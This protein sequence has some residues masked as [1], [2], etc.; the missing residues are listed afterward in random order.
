MPPDEPAARQAGRRWRLGLAA[1][2]AGTVVGIVTSLYSAEL[3]Q[4]LEG[5]VRG[6]A[7]GALPFLVTAAVASV[8]GVLSYELA[9]RRR[10]PG[11]ITAG[12]IT[13]GT[14][15][16]DRIVD[17]D[18]PIAGRSLHY[19]ETRRHTGDLVVLLHGLG[20]DANDFRAYLAES[21]HHC[22]ALTLY[23]FNVA[24]RDHPHY[25]PIS[26]ESHA[27]LVGYALQ[28]LRQTYP[29]K[30]ITLVGFSIG[31][32][33]IMLLSELDRE[34]LAQ[35]RIRA[36]VLLDPNVNTATTTISS[37][38]AEVGSDSSLKDLVSVLR[39]AK[40]RAEFRYLCEYLTKIT[41]KDFAQVRRQ[42]Q[43]VAGRYRQ[44]SFGPFLDAAGALA[45]VTEG[46]QVVLSLNHEAVFNALVRAA[47]ARGF[48]VQQLTCSR[49]D[50]FE[51]I[52]PE[53]LAEQLRRLG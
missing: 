7:A 22:V 34:L 10:Q 15:V 1:S 47:A 52:H 29:R 53:I 36:A 31:A 40:S 25:Q 27:H 45:S 4:L 12:T 49:T 20:L 9:V 38:I 39:S 3:R 21:A 2:F 41:S 8:S 16:L 32:D 48:D 19:L 28:K 23:G 37:K 44:R 46:I 17:E 11:T 26:L 5:P 13:I 33:L 24:E 18:Q 30:R 51:L 35:L 6:M 42:A 14:D 43:D 50:H